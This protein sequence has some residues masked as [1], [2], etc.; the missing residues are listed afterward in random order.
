MDDY[1]QWLQTLVWVACCVLSIIL[2][3]FSCRKA[4][5]LLTTHPIA[6]LSI[7]HP[8]RVNSLTTKIGWIITI[9]ALLS[10][11]SACTLFWA[12]EYTMS[13]VWNNAGYILSDIMSCVAL[14]AVHWIQ[15]KILD[16]SFNPMDIKRHGKSTNSS[17]TA[18]LLLK[19]ITLG[20]FV[21]HAILMIVHV[22]RWGLS[23]NDFIYQKVD[24]TI[25]NPEILTSWNLDVRIPTQVSTA[26]AL[27]HSLH[28]IQIWFE[29]FKILCLLYC[30]AA[31]F[32]RLRNMVVKH[33]CYTNDLFYYHTKLKQATTNTILFAIIFCWLTIVRS[34]HLGSSLIYW[35]HLE[36]GLQSILHSLGAHGITQENFLSIV[37]RDFQQ[38]FK[39]LLQPYHKNCALWALAEA[40]QIQV[41]FAFCSNFF[42]E[43][44]NASCAGDSGSRGENPHPHG[45]V[46]EAN[47][48]SSMDNRMDP[49]VSHVRK[50]NS[51]STH[52]EQN[53][54]NGSMNPQHKS[55]SEMATCNTSGYN[56]S[57]D[58]TLNDAVTCSS[59]VDKHVQRYNRHPHIEK[60]DHTSTSSFNCNPR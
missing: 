43:W 3:V 29:V 31:Y 30:V 53:N 12:E 32:Y 25:I 44:Q 7:I 20:S 6:Q 2:T 16:I 11:I 54:D 45:A 56:S 51:S 10:V 17:Y 28:G 26:M 60:H 37:S 41:T 34:I 36:L 19:C 22:F 21:T 39:Q 14:H 15:I 47:M 9:G 24:E 23:E 8:D 38:Y 58:T 57:S 1:E 50:V 42:Y 46:V 59:T 13:V 18:I 35:R 48:D 55:V 5:S 40:V 33:V 49:I 4:L 52:D 27:I